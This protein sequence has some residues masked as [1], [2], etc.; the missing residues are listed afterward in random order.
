[1][2]RQKLQKEE[3]TMRLSAEKERVDRS[4]DN[5]E[6]ELQD[7]QRQIAL[8]QVFTFTPVSHSLH[9][10]IRFNNAGECVFLWI[11]M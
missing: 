4:L 5:A 2:E 9:T 10:D 1:M 8:L 3:S 6:K 7:A 11:C